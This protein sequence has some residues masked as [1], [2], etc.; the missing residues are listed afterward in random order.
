LGVVHR[1][2][3]VVQI[4]N[5]VVWQTMT[6]RI[7]PSLICLMMMKMIQVPVLVVPVTVPVA[8]RMATTRILIV[9]IQGLMMI[10]G[11]QDQAQMTH[12]GSG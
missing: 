11:A 5:A 12:N 9:M 10:V 2:L 6:A 8:V 3:R 4:A 7:V 1:E